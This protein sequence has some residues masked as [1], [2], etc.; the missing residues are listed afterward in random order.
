MCTRADGGGGGGGGGS[1]PP[2]P[3]PPLFGNK[4]SW[5]L[6]LLFSNYSHTHI[7][8]EILLLFS[9][10]FGN[11]LPGPSYGPVTALEEDW[12][13]L[14]MGLFSMGYILL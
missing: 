2:P 4:Y 3:P 13:K 1:G 5:K 14:D 9:N 8:L 10:Y 7:I 12:T 6:C 11:N